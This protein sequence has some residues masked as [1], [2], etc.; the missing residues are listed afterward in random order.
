VGDRR[1]Q[2][3][4][5]ALTRTQ[6]V[7][8]AGAT[9]DLSPLHTDEPAAQAAGHP[10]IMGHGMMTM[11][12]AARVLT[13]WF[14]YDALRT[15]SARFTAPVWPGD[16]VTAT[17]T[18]ESVETVGAVTLARV[19]LSAENQDGLVVLVG[20]ATAALDARSTAEEM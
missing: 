10:S 18:V 13:Q 15:L 1:R 9:G 17:A 12:A 14:G 19:A 5:E 2:V 4:V 20:S 7:Q 11:A 6:V 16:E 8:Y 3:V